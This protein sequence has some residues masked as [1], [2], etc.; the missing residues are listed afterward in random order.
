VWN[1]GGVDA[2]KREYHPKGATGVP[3]RTLVR[4]LR[5]WKAA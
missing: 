1:D 2:P 5:D 4:M 3:V